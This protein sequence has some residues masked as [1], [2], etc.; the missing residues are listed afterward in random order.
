MAVVSCTFL[1]SM[2]VGGAAGEGVDSDVVVAVAGVE[3][4]RGA[5]VWVGAVVG[6]DVAAA[7]RQ[8]MDS[9]ETVNT[10][11]RMSHLIRRSPLVAR[12][13]VLP[14]G[15]RTYARPP[16]GYGAPCPPGLYWRKGSVAAR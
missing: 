8:A 13:G 2:G 10:A 11:S 5:G 1:F 16:E 7:P 12:H 9:D 3:A 14:R 4:G 15:A 6:P